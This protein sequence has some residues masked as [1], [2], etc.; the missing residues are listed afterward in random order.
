MRDD[1]DRQIAWARIVRGR[2][3]GELR[4]IGVLAR[5]LAWRLLAENLSAPVSQRD[6]LDLSHARALV[7]EIEDLS[8]K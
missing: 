1:D 6:P 2:T 8:P 7:N 5:W 3:A 4:H